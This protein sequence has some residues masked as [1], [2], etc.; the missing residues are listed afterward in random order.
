M[1]IRDRPGVDGAELT[2]RGIKNLDATLDW[3]FAHGLD[4]ATEF[5]LTGGSAGGL[6]TFLHS[7][8][9]AE[10]LRQQAP[11]IG[12]I[13]AA[14]VV[15]Y[16]LDHDNFAH[17]TGVP[18]TPSFTEANYTTWMI[19]IYQMQNLTFGADGG[20]TKACEEKHPSQPW[21][22]FMSPHMQDVIQTPFF[23]FNSKYDAWQLQNEF[24]SD[25][26]TKPE[27]EG[28]L[29]YGKDFLTQF[30]PVSSAAKNGAFITSCICHGCPWS[31][32]TA[33]NF[34]EGMAP[35]KAYARWMAGVDAGKDAIHVDPRLPNGGGEIQNSACKAF[36]N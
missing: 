35:Y 32:E 6:S 20:L 25:W 7:D 14:P 31:N 13:R 23:V 10:R 2:F 36:P 26:A 3:A 24:Q 9:V 17:S 15:G 11:D 19:H 4:K 8:R 28:V 22:C 1:C 27:Q 18:N 30:A 33:L 21:L 12:K 34:V 16:F 29:Q 5:V